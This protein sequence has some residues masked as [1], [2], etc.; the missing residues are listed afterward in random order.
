MLKNYKSFIVLTDLE[1]DDVLAL[2]IFFRGVPPVSEVLIVVGESNVNKVLFAKKM[3]PFI[4]SHHR[5]IQGC[6]SSK[7]FVDIND[8]CD[9]NSE[10]DD[11]EK[12]IHTFLTQHENTFIFSIKP[13]RE[14]FSV[15]V[16]L[17]R[18]C[19]IAQYGSANFRFMMNSKSKE[20]ISHFMNNSFKMVILYESYYVTKEENSIN[21][22]NA[23]ELFKI[24]EDGKRFELL[25]NFIGDWNDH[26]AIDC[27]NTVHT[28]IQKLMKTWSK[29]DWKSIRSK[30]ERIQNR[31]MKVVSDIAKADG[32]QMVLADFGLAALLNAYDLESLKSCCV[33]GDMYF[34]EFGYTNVNTNTEGTNNDN[35]DTEGT[36][37]DNNDNGKILLISDIGFQKMVE[38]ITKELLK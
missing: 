14:L 20:D 37:N 2:H 35:N 36:N 13:P 21:K 28:E 15:D 26:I 3:L 12:E 16:K 17:L 19:V 38:I 10:C 8:K 24:I 32:M 31:N 23:P 34:N 4:G 1:P 30:C 5:I 18:D 6:K 25:R 33:K 7:D 29:K 27:L 9:D 22:T 11:A